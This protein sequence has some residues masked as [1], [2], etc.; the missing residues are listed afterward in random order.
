M[1]HSR[2]TFSDVLDVLPELFGLCTRG[3][4]VFEF[5]E[6]IC[7]RTAIDSGFAKNNSEQFGSF[8]Q[9]DFPFKNMGAVSSLDLFGLDE[10]ILFSV[11]WR[12]R[13]RY[14]TFADLGA[15]LGLHSL[16]ASRL[17]WA[18]SAYEPDPETFLQMS[19]NFSKNETSIASYQC[20]VGS[21]DGMR[22]FTRVR[23]NLT[24]SHL[25]GAKQRP[26]GDLEEFEVRVQNFRGIVQANDFLKI[27]VEGAEAEIFCSTSTA[28]WE[29]AEAV[30]EIGSEENAAE[31]FLHLK[32]CPGLNIFSQK[33][34]WNVVVTAE[35]LP[36]HHREGSVF[37][38]LADEAP[39]LKVSSPRAKP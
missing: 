25:S 17:G 2:T 33:R 24:G 16:L 19:E 28:D 31:I 37:I 11:Y 4:Q 13:D 21:A 22:S 6:Q 20:A 30:M 1:T 7:S 34:G 29:T 12:L 35:D 39:F 8:G 15:N 27:D 32:R 9:I 14:K 26:Y 18:V 3:T 38:S 10:M 36:M 5:L 23:G